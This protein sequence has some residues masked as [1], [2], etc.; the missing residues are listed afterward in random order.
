MELETE[1]PKPSRNQEK[2][3]DRCSGSR[4]S[5]AVEGCMGASDILHL[6]SCRDDDRF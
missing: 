1:N 2:S 3:R 4:K 5:A 6:A